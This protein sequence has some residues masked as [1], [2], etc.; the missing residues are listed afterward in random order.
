MN[1][2]GFSLLE[3][4]VAVV[5]ITI[6]TAIAV[7]IYRHV[8]ERARRTQAIEALE[9]AASREEGYFSRYNTYAPTLAS[10]GYAAATMTTDGGYYAMD[11]VSA[12]ATMFQLRAVPQGA[13]ANDDCGT[14]R[15]D[16][17]GNET[18]QGGTAGASDCWH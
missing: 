17:K 10:L 16:G 5:I 9:T 15:L 14:F 12:S 18:V 4:V 2:K 13:Q 8:Q 3:L 1:Q 6:L 7:P 11:I